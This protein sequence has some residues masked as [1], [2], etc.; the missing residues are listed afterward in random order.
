M[1]QYINGVIF[2]I[3]NDVLNEV[4][5]KGCFSII[6]KLLIFYK[7]RYTDIIFFQSVSKLSICPNGLLAP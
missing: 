1:C 4:D 5:R 3:M 2:G 7:R 6:S